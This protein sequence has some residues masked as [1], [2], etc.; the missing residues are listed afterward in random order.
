MDIRGNVSLL[1]KEGGIS[2]NRLIKIPVRH[3]IE[4]RVNDPMRQFDASTKHRLVARMGLR[5]FGIPP[6]C[7]HRFRFRYSSFFRQRPV[8]HP[9]GPQAAMP[10]TA[11]GVRMRSHRDPHPSRESV[12]NRYSGAAGR[13][14]ESFDSTRGQIFVRQAA[15][16]LKVSGSLH[17]DSPIR[18]F[19]SGPR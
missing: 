11:S 10:L 5:E 16:V 9:L 2:W 18:S 7:S 8:R 15:G 14:S 4:I 13:A 17:A 3:R 6:Q 12:F 19:R 1:L